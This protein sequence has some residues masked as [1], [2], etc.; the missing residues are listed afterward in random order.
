MCDI[1]DHVVYTTY[2]GTPQYLTW[3]MM[4]FR[5]VWAIESIIRFICF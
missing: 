2:L 3:I 4:A 1:G 5:F